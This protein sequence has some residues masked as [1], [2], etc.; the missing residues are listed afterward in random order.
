MKRLFPL[1]LLLTLWAGCKKTTYEY[2]I[3][4]N[5]PTFFQGP[6]WLVVSNDAGDI[7]KTIELPENATEFVGKFDYKAIDATDTYNL[8]LVHQGN[9]IDPSLIASCYGVRNGSPVSFWPTKVYRFFPP[10]GSHALFIH[11]MEAE[12]DSVDIPGVRVKKYETWGYQASTKTLSIDIFSLLPADVV[13]RVRSTPTA[14][15]RVLYLTAAALS[16]E[17]IEAQWADFVPEDR[18]ATVYLPNTTLPANLEVMAVAPDFRRYVE[19]AKYDS[20]PLHQA[21]LPAGLDPQSLFRVRMQ[22]GDFTAEKMFLPGEALRFEAPDFSIKS[23]VFSP[24]QSVEVVTEG[25]PELIEVNGFI[26]I[27]PNPPAIFQW[28]IQATPEAFAKVM[29]PDLQDIV[30]ELRDF[31]A[32]KL[33]W[34]VNA[35]KYTQLNYEQLLA[36]FPLKGNDGRLFPVARAGLQIITKNY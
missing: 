35:Y 18:F 6:N 30:P 19:L 7:L 25:Q 28:N 1:L 2:A 3:V 21:I 4:C 22:Q 9:P 36:G 24:F 12:A 14:P 17:H 29:L 10:R 16:N 23:A 32:Q 34:Q 5:F 33:F 15:F 11:G 8:H 13:V 20:I 26:T 27:S 31:D